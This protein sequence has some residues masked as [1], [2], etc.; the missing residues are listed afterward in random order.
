MCMSN[1]L[2]YKYYFKNNN[3]FTSSQT[4]YNEMQSTFNLLILRYLS[5]FLYILM[6]SVTRTLKMLSMNVIF[7]KLTVVKGK[8]DKRSI[9]VQFLIS[10]DFFYNTI[11]I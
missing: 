9:F 8:Q 11:C 5:H 4:S 6:L 7:F 3:K 10:V 1:I 2:F